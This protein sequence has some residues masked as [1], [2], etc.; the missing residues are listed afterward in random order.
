[1]TELNEDLLRRVVKRIERDEENWDQSNWA[2][3]H[4]MTLD[5]LPPA[6]KTRVPGWSVMALV[7]ELNDDM[8][9]ECGTTCC[10][11][12]HTV[13]EAGEKLLVGPSGHTTFCRTVDGEIKS[14]PDRARELL[15]LDI[16]QSLAIFDGEAAEELGDWGPMRYSVARMKNLIQQVTGVDVS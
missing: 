12:G 10:V 5:R 2:F 9:T 6:V 13:L 7:R 3:T 16:A 15:G 14:V 4:P 1:M 8:A 11:A